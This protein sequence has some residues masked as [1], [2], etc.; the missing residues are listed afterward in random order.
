MPLRFDPES[1]KGRPHPGLP[2]AACPMVQ[3]DFPD[4]A[5]R[6]KAVRVAGRVRRDL[7]QTP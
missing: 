5:Y 6:K 1:G 7:R 2:E 3:A 4:H